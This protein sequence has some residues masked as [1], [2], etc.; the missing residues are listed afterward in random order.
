LV[1]WCTARASGCP[2]PIPVTYSGFVDD[3]SVLPASSQRVDHGTQVTKSARP[4]GPRDLPA[5]APPAPLPT[6]RA[7]VNVTRKSQNLTPPLPDD[8]LNLLLKI[9]VARLEHYIDNRAPRDDLD[10]R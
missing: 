8:K 2:K 6:N 7:D 5:G 1:F 10:V 3:D 9:P 4:I